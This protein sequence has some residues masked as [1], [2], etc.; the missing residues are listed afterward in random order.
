MQAKKFEEERELERNR[1]SDSESSSDEYPRK[2]KDRRKSSSSNKDENSRK[3]RK[4]KHEKDNG[5]DKHAGSKKQLPSCLNPECDENH[6]VRNCP[7]TPEELKEKLLNEFRGQKKR[8]RKEKGSSSSPAKGK[9]NR[10][11]AERID[12]HS[13]LFSAFFVMGLWKLL[14]WPI[15]ALTST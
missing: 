8:D 10:I 14:S 12:S 7:K 4:R 1:Q 9:V 11:S 13:S 2:T 5:K 3:D 15:K 6:Y